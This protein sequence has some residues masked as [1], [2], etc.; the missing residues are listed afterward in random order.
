LLNL[1]FIELILGLV[2]LSP[3][4]SLYGIILKSFKNKTARA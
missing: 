2:I 1:F 3:L 4:N